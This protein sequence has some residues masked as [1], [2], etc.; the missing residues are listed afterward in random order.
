M[1]STRSISRSAPLAQLCNKKQKK[2]TPVV[3]PTNIYNLKYAYVRLSDP[4]LLALVSCC[5]IQVMS[6]YSNAPSCS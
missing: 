3:T 5:G 1:H 2:Q 4:E 6:Y